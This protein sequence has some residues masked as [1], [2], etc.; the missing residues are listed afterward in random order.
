MPIDPNQEMNFQFS[1]ESLIDPNEFL[2]LLGVEFPVIYAAIDSDHLDL[3]HLVMAEVARAT[4]KAI[5]KRDWD[6]V[7]SHFAFMESVL[8]NANEAVANAICVSYLENL[9]F[10]E[11]DANHLYAKSLLPEKLKTSFAELEAHF[12]MLSRFQADR[13]K[14]N[15]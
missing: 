9:L 10:G 2:G 5:D 3:I 12:E 1:N 4:S 6:Q 13:L 14:A 11:A 15:D 7:R 8:S